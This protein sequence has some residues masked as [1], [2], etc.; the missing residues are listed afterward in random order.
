MNGRPAISAANVGAAQRRRAD[1]ARTAQA[2]LAWTSAGL[3]VLLLV[4][5]LILQVLSGSS[6]RS[7]LVT[8]AIIAIGAMF[9]LVGA[10]LVARRPHNIIGW[11][12]C[13]MGLGEA[14]TAFAGHY[15]IYALVAHPGVLP[16]G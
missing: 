10:F 1:L 12:L 11:I 8:P 4:L 7:N 13:A 3:C 5:A 2:W 16:G 6:A 15:A 9:P 14:L